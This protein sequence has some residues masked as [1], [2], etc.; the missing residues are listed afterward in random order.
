MKVEKI[1]ET[2]FRKM[3]LTSSDRLNKNAE[4][5]NSLNVFP[6]PDGDTGTN[7]SLS[8]ASGSKY[9][10]ESTSANVGD[11]AQALAKGLLMGAR[12]NSGVILSQVFRGFAKSVSNKK[13]LTP[14]DLAQALQ[15]GVET[16]YKA[17]MKPQEGTILTVARKSAEA[18]KKVAK[19]DGDIVAVMKDTYEAAEAALKTTP[20]LLP[21]LK[22]VGVV[23]SGGQGLTFVYQGFYDALS[24]N[25][26][27]DEVHKPS[28]VEMD[29]MVSAEHHK[30]A[31]GKLN[32]ED[33]KYG[34]CTEIMVRLGAGRLVEKKFDYDEF[35]GYL[36]EIG[37][38]LLVIADDEVVKVHVHTEHPGMVLS[39]GQKFGSL[40]KV[41]VD[42]MRLQHETILEKDEEEEREEEISEN[43]I[44]GD[45]GIIAIASGE[46]VAEIFK[47]LGATYVLSGGQ[48]M[49][50]STKDI[51]DAIAK[52]KKDKVII[53]PNNKNIFLA[54]DQAAE[55]CDVDAVVVPSKTIAQGMAAMLG[56]SKD[57]DLEENKEAM[58]D[59]LD[60]VISGQVTIAVRDT[61][62]E[63]RE[64]KKDDYMGI[65]DGNIVVTNPDR[66]EAAIEMVK[67]MLDEDSEVVTIIYGEDGNKE[68]AEAIETAV[69]E[70]DEDL[71][72]EIHEGN[73]PVYPYLISVE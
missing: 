48:T 15:G 21:V 43:E 22:E 61:T 64:I 28:P 32:T 38:S 19:D 9:V 53:L 23:D 18:A 17:V 36:A 10:S 51:V 59:E 63:G 2:E 58:T 45:Y 5:I 12:G 50:P 31:Q 41:K 4:F 26:R 71:E 25:V 62:I 49:N 29:E 24:G 68:E 67:A 14:Q 52:T 3:I 60:T 7:M 44:S 69:S 73:Q 8:F 16:A 6:V 34:Y 11:L 72:I 30:S 55:V 37:D 39:Y 65:V 13:E 54:A 42:N 66:K 40:I 47:N 35:R 33:I 56:F 27:D 57:A 1:T 20:D 70:L 46:G